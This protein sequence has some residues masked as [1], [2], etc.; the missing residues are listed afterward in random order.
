MLARDSHPSHQPRYFWSDKLY[1]FMAL[2]STT[3]LVSLH[4][5]KT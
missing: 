5:I 4:R 2:V 3:Y 1:Q